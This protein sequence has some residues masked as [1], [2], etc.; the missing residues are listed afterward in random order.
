M[1]TLPPNQDALKIFSLDDKLDPSFEKAPIKTEKI[2]NI[3]VSR[4]QSLKNKLAAASSIIKTR[5]NLFL[6]Q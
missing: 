3:K 6:Y 2:E 4:F 1:V 5:V